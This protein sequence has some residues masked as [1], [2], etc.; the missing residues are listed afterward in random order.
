M[1][2][3]LES[4]PLDRGVRPEGDVQVGVRRRADGAPVACTAA[5]RCHGGVAGHVHELQG[6]ALAVQ[7]VLQLGGEEVSVAAI[8]PLTAIT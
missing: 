5:Q 7:A 8:Y 2:N 4:P 3:E 1:H 6:V